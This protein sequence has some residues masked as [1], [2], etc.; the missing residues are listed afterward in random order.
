MP[1]SPTAIETP[2]ASGLG[3]TGGQRTAEIFAGLRAELMPSTE[4]HALSL[5]SGRMMAKLMMRVARPKVLN[6]VPIRLGGFTGLIQQSIAQNIYGDVTIVEMGAGFSPRGLHLAR[7]MPNAIVIEI[8]LP[9]VI[10]E[11]QKRLSRIPNFTPPANLLWRSAD[12][13]V[14]PLADVLNGEAADVVTAEGLLPYFSLEEITQIGK[15]V[16]DCL[17]PGGKF[18]ADIGY[19]TAQGK[20]Q[21]GQLVRIFNRQT[22]TTPGTVTEPETARQLFV[23]ADFSQVQMYS[24]PEVA[25]MYDL[26]QPAPDV[27]F[28]MVGHK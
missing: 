9:D 16:R 10:E 15:S 28:F 7:T 14:T 17:K 3:R 8:D 19:M 20:Q 2:D 6:F 23:D 25:Q 13:G 4:T 5:R 11:K 1:S 22:R 12:L 24:M 21:A 18:I 26:P 27:L